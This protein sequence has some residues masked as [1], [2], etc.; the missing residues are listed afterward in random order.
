MTDEIRAETIA[1][2]DS[3]ASDWDI[4]VGERGDINRRLNSDPVLWRL[5]GNVRGRDVLDAGCG[6]GYL[7]RQLQEAGASVVGVDISPR[8]IEI[9]RGNAPGIDFRVDSCSE[10]ASVADSTIDVII[11]NYVL[12]DTPDLHGAVGAFSRVLR[13]GGIAVLVFSHP[14]FPQGSA[15]GSGESTQYNWE[16]GYFDECKRVDPPWGH[17]TADFIWF[18]RPLSAYWKAF[19]AH[20]FLVEEFDEPRVAPE[21]FDLAEDAHSLQKLRTRPMSVA[22]RLRR[23]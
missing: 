12:M 17:F 18:H 21:H 16:F 9:A 7:S 2:W 23:P 15:T 22:F 11:S 6:T 3:V 1:F 4:Q 20:G 10:L 13:V 19:S 14:C 8:M 5:A